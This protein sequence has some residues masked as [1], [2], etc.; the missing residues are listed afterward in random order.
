MLCS[1]VC[2]RICKKCS[3][4]VFPF[5]KIVPNANATHLHLE[6]YITFVS[7]VKIYLISFSPAGP[8]QFHCGSLSISPAGPRQF[9]YCPKLLLALGMAK[10]GCSPCQVFCG[11]HS[12]I[13]TSSFSNAKSKISIFCNMRSLAEA[14]IRGMICF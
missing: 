14:L 1:K 12:N 7:F 9:L 3:K 13:C 5:K 4:I 11:M 10:S 6:L 2:S 8:R